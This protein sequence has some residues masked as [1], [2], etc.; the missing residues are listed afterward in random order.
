MLFASRHA[1]RILRFRI[2]LLAAQAPS[3]ALVEMAEGIAQRLG[4]RKVP[5][6]LLLPVRLS[7]LVWWLGGRPRALLPA[8]LFEQAVQ[9]DRHIFRPSNLCSGDSEAGRDQPS[10]G[11]RSQSPALD[12]E[13]QQAILAHEL[14][15]VRRKD[16]WVRLLEL[17]MV[18]LF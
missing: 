1:Y 14:A 6:I 4:L 13:A 11:A 9:R 12:V 15:H 8:A 17:A 7:P 2:L 3:P 5:E 18:T 16:H 10:V